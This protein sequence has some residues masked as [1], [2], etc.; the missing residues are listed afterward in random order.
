MVYILKDIKQLYR[1]PTFF[2]Q[3]VFPVIIILISAIM[4]GN[5]IIPIIDEAIQSS[6]NIQNTL[7][8]LTFNTEMVCIVLGILQVLFS[9]SDLSL[10]AISR[11]GKNAVF[12]KYIP[13]D[14]YKQFLYK[15][16]LQ[17]GLNTIVSIVVLGILYFLISKIS[18]LQILLLF[19][20]SIFIS[21]I[22]SFLMLIV[23]LRRPNLNWSSE[24]VLIKKNENKIFQYVFMI[25]MILIFLYLSN[26]LQE[27]NIH[28][29]I[30]IQMM[31]FAIIFMIMNI[32]VKKK[33]NKLF[34][35]II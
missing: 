27:M 31:L 26:I 17:V 13:I 12:I 25:I 8:Q 28:I 29:A 7:R 15:N 18:V 1:V 4:I 6:E 22:N 34:N 10:T 33:I 35:K 14:L 9:M 16:I 23:D 5:F 20:T 11:E 19:I 32:L 3:M 2:M 30:V 21:L 24:Y